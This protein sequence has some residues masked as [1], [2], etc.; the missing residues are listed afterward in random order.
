MQAITA[1]Q[2]F[3]AAPKAAARNLSARRTTK[4]LAPRCVCQLF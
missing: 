3:I 2:T 4:A 1:S